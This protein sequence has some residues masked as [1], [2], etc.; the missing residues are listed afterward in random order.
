MRSAP[1]SD[2]L[3]SIDHN[4]KQTV[5]VLDLTEAANEAI[6]GSNSLDDEQRGWIREHILAGV[7][8]IRRHKKML[9]GAVDV[10]LLKPLRA[11]YEAVAEAPAKEAILAAINAIRSMFGL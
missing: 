7:E 3:V 10:L 11:A 4:S 8:F 5:E 1:A 2:R 9:A 6:R